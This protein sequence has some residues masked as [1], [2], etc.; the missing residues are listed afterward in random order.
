MVTILSGREVVSFWTTRS[1]AT[2]HY[3]YLSYGGVMAAVLFEIWYVFL[4]PR[5]IFG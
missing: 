4:Y 2:P 5:P 1:Y 3:K